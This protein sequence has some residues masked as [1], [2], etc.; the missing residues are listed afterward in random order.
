MLVDKVVAVEVAEGCCT[1]TELKQHVAHAIPALAGG[2]FDVQVAGRA[3]GDGDVRGLAAGCC[4]DLV[5][6]RRALTAAALREAGRSVDDAGLRGAVRAGDAELCAL[7][8]QAGLGAAPR[9]GRR[10]AAE[11][12]DCTDGYELLHVAARAGSRAVCDLLLDNGHPLAPVSDEGFTPLHCAAREDSSDVCALLLAKGHPVSPADKE[13]YT[14]LHLAALAGSYGPC[15]LLLEKGHVVA[16]VDNTGATPLHYA[17]AAGHRRVCEVLL[18]KGHPST[19]LDKLGHTPRD[20]AECQ[21]VDEVFKKA[22][23]H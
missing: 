9:C 13:G 17:V 23:A 8:L 20:Y 12:A 21:Y 3:I 22:A 7:Y 5:A 16:P 2:G 15:V 4:V 10:A 14:P 18:E 19:V 6:S 1:L 11:A